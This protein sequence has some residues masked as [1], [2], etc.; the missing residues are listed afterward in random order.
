MGATIRAQLN[1]AAVGLQRI[2]L[3]GVQV[4][5]QTSGPWLDLGEAVVGDAD[6]TLGLSA[7]VDMHTRQALTI[8]GIGGA[9][10]AL[11]QGA[12][13]GVNISPGGGVTATAPNVAQQVAGGVGAG[14]LQ[15]GAQMATQ[16]SAMAPTLTAPEAK[17]VTLTLDRDLAL[18][19]YCDP[20]VPNSIE[21][22][23]KEYLNESNP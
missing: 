3:T 4:Q 14:I 21:C 13:G 2:G 10:A 7:H 18:E 5:Y 19:P 23:V 12:F 20:T 17:P 15:Q 8:A 16:A 9:M 11:S 1:P 6:G 22:R